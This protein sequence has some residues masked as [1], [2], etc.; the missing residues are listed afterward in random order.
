MARRRLFAS[1]LARWNGLGGHLLQAAPEGGGLDL[2]TLNSHW[3][4]GGPKGSE[5]DLVRM[6]F[7][8]LNV[9]ALE[10]PG[11]F[12]EVGVWR[13]NS[14]MIMHELAPER[15]LYLFDTFTG[16]DAADVTDPG[17]LAHFRD[18]SEA[19]VRGFLGG[20]QAIRIVSGWFPDTAGAVPGEERFALVHLDCD[21][22]APTQAA[23]AFFYPRMSPG[24]IVVIHDYNSGRWPGLRE[25]VDA[26][27]AD[28]PESLIRIPDRDGSV[29]FARM[30]TA[31]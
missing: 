5:R 16:F 31:L 10:V 23:L 18:T 1:L 25:V 2:R 7:L 11:A 22:A 26:F 21:L 20:S 17:H 14:A 15:L 28:K 24:G 12:A 6:L 19:Q 3:N 30:R 27:L 13:G 8:A 29:V 4:A 9:A